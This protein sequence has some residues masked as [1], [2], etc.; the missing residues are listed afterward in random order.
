MKASEQVYWIKAALGLITG[1]L[2]YYVQTGFGLQGQLAFMIGVTLYILYSEALA[3]L[4][5]V[6]RNR[7]IKIAMGAFLFLWMLTWTLLNTM[8]ISGWI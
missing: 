3:V 1:G 7:T 2:C 8:S 6:D 5:K 4:I